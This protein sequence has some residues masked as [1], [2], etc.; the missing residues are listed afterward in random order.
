M[1]EKPKASEKELKVPTWANP[2]KVLKV[3]TW[4]NRSEGPGKLGQDLD[5]KSVQFFGLSP[6][7]YLGALADAEFQLEVELSFG[8]LLH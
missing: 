2:G 3:P 1:S 5:E 8:V 7:E 4:V 6:E